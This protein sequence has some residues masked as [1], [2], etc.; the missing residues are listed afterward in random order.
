MRVW[1]VV[2]F[3]VSSLFST[4]HATIPVLYTDI[5][6]N[7]QEPLTLKDLLRHRNLAFGSGAQKLDE[8][9]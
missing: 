4:A 5:F 2:V 7:M 8:Y 9:R 3:L 6:P 1:G